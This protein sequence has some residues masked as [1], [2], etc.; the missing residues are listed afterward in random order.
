MSKETIYL[1]RLRKFKRVEAQRFTQGGFDFHIRKDFFFF[2]SKT[3]TWIITECGSGA[4]FADGETALS[5]LLLMDLY[6]VWIPKKHLDKSILITKAKQFNFLLSEFNY[7][8][9]C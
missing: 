5:A 7:S 2:G 6:L 1:H 3:K 8:G 4:V 9:I